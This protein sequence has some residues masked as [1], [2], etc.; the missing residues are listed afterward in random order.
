M[1][2]QVDSRRPPFHTPYYAMPLARTLASHSLLRTDTTLPLPCILPKSKYIQGQEGAAQTDTHAPAPYASRRPSANPTVP[3]HDPRNI[4]VVPLRVS[5]TC[6]AK[7]ARLITH[8]SSLI[9]HHS[10]LRC[11]QRLRR[12]RRPTDQHQNRSQ[13]Q[14]Q[15]WPPLRARSAAASPG[16]RCGCARR[17]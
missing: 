14:R 3:A 6:F 11:L 15:P 13:M 10:R 1:L 9:T 16:R 17:P 5:A 12:W 8:H 7:R 2:N 4:K